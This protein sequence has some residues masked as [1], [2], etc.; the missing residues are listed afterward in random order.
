MYKINNTE[1]ELHAPKSSETFT[2]GFMADKLKI[3]G[4]MN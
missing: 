1:T 3:L 2:E 4:V